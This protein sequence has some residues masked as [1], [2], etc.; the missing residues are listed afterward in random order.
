MSGLKRIISGEMSQ[1]KGKQS[2]ADEI[3][4]EE[5]VQKDIETLAEVKKENLAFTNKSAYIK[6]KVFEYKKKWWDKLDSMICSD[7]KDEV[8]TAFVEYNKLQSK[9]LPTEITGADGKE[10]PTALVIN[11]NKDGANANNTSD[12]EAAASVAETGGQDN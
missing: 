12:T 7:D 3:K 9:I 2:M 1:S 10:L 4:T 6:E 11:L 8:K 5:L